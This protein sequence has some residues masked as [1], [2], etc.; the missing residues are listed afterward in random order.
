MKQGQ[1][2][3]DQ[4]ELEFE[5]GN[6]YEPVEEKDLSKPGSKCVHRWT[7]FVRTKDDWIDVKKLIKSVAFEL[8]ETYRGENPVVV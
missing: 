6:H 3:E 1:L 7:A 4:I 5:I 8:H 2:I